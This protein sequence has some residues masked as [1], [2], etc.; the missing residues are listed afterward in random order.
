MNRFWFSVRCWL[1]IKVT[2]VYSVFLTWNYNY[3]F[4]KHINLLSTARRLLFIPMHL[5]NNVDVTELVSKVW[6]LEFC[7]LK[8]K[9]ANFKSCISYIH[10]RPLY[11]QYFTPLAMQQIVA[12]PYF[13]ISLLNPLYSTKNWYTAPQSKR[14]ASS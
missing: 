7:F 6:Q 13:P 1:M 11:N 3:Y 2:L 9:L 8:I 10:I 4:V 12:F 5:I 14:L